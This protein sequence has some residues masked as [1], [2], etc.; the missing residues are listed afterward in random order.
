MKLAAILSILA[1]LIFAGCASV[2]EQTAKA[3]IL[4]TDTVVEEWHEMVPGAY[5]KTVDG[6]FELWFKDDAEG[7]RNEKLER[8]DRKYKSSNLLADKLA[9]EIGHKRTGE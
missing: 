5:R 1:V 8:R 2:Q 4:Q 6:E 9:E 7:S 3:Y